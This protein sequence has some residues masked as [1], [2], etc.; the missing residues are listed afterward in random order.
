VHSRT[1]LRLG[2]PGSRMPPG[3]GT[4]LT[5]RR[6]PHLS[7]VWCRHGLERGT[8][9][10]PFRGRSWRGLHRHALMTMIAYAFLQHRRLTQARREKKNQRT[11]ASAKLASRFQNAWKELYPGL[12]EWVSLSMGRKVTSVDPT[13]NTR[14]TDFAKHEAK[15]ANVIPPQ[16]AGRVAER[17]G[18]VDQTGWCLIDPMTF[19]SRL[20]PNIHVIGD[21][22]IAGGMPKSAFAANAQAK[23]SAAAVV[24]LSEAKRLSPQS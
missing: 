15:V 20:Q 1:T 18:V 19:E 7:V 14:V 17:A 23:V 2:A 13:T 22:A 12:L 6:W 3:I 9:P 11:T 16:K 8:R 5:L 24:K 4:A 10:Q 21:A